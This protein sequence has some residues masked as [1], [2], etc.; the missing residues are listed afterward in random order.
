[1]KMISKLF[2]LPLLAICAFFALN[3]SSAMAAPVT[4]ATAAAS[5]K[6]FIQDLGE[7]AINSLTDGSENSID[8]TFM[9][10]LDEG[11]DIN[12]IAGFVMGRNWKSFTPTQKENFIE[13]FRQRLKKTYAVH[14]KDYKGVEF[15]VKSSRNEARGEIVQ[16]VIQKP[17][18][19]PVDVNWM[20][21][22]TA[23]RYKIHDVVVA[24]ISMSQTMRSDYSASY[25]QHGANPDAFIESLKG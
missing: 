7:R 1:M 12:Y 21:V 23:G 14:F 17:G 24:G 15:K 13:I 2:N 11:F 8:T 20:V 6:I 16:T 22:R 19:A 3:D 5:A 4:A 18:G 10:L 25:Q 9:K